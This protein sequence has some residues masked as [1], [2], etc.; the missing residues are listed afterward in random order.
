[1]NRTELATLIVQSSPPNSLTRTQ[2]NFVIDS[3]GRIAAEELRR[4]GTFT[5]PGVAK[6]AVA[7]KAASPARMGRHPITGEPLRIKAKPATDV[8]R[9]KP[10][11]PLKESVAARPRRG[12]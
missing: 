11:K 6:L 12:R 8:V 9:A 1:M 7:H 10:L 2:V 3:I 5:I 4:E